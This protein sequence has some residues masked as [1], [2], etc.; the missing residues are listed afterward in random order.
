MY[1]FINI[2]KSLLKTTY[3][4]MRIYKGHEQ[5]KPIFDNICQTSK[6]ELS[7]FGHQIYNVFSNIA[8]CFWK[9]VDMLNGTYQHEKSITYITRGFL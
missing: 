9:G 3:F 2:V 8:N 6:N 4:V 1:T 7:Q 5:L